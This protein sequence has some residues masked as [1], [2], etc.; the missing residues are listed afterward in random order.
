[1]RIVY[2]TPHY[3]PVVGGAELH[4]QALA[5]HHAARGHKVTIFTQRTSDAVTGAV[6]PSLPEEEDIGA[7]KV[8]RFGPDEALRRR[9]NRF[10]KLRGAWRLARSFLSAEQMGA[11]FEGPLLTGHVLRA[12]WARPHVITTVNWGFAGFVLPFYLARRL[13]RAPIVGMPLLH[14]EIPWT[15][16][17]ATMDMI[18]GS[19]AIL[20]NT[21]HEVRFCGARGFPSNRMY[22]C[23][24]GAD[25]TAFSNPD[26]RRLRARHGLGDGP[27]VGYVGRMQVD[28]GVPLLIEAM[29]L[30]WRSNPRVRLLLAGRDL[31]SATHDHEAFHAALG[32]LDP[33]TVRVSFTS[34]ASPRRTRRRSSRP[35]TSTRCRRSAT[36]SV[37]RF[38]RR[39]CAVGP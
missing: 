8:I 26:G 31:P 12:L 27:V 24:A 39:G 36:R 15:E 2:V 5:E 28:K 4:V 16:S 33:R 22:V 34:T 9:L 13:L 21:E 1:M 25:P 30:V 11:L 32:G 6:D 3:V 35:A 23:G 38:S 19:D 37:R 17:Q 10:L 20:A 7:V 18:A 29:R 14:T